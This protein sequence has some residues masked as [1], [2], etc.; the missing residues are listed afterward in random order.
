MFDTEGHVVSKYT[1]RM[2]S[3]YPQ[4]GWVEQDPYYIL[5]A[6]KTSISKALK[7][8]G[9]QPS[10]I[11]C[12]GITNQRETTIIWDR[13]T[14]IPVYNA[15]LW[16]DRRTETI[17]K[18]LSDYSMEISKK[19][20]LRLDP[21]FSAGKIKWILDNV[22][23]ARKRAMDGDLVF[24][25][26]DSWILFNLDRSRPCYTDYTNASRTML[27]DIRKL[28]WDSG[29]LSMFGIPDILLPDVFPSL[30]EFGSISIGRNKEIPVYSIIG[31]Q[32]SALFG[33]SSTSS[34]MAKITYGTGSFAMLNTGTD[35]PQSGALINTVA[36]GI[37][38]RKV[39]YALEGSVFSAGFALDWV[40]NLLHVRSFARFEEMAEK[41]R[42]QNSFMVP[43]FS[44]M[45]SPYWDPDA[46]GL[47]IG[48][49]GSSGR[50]DFARMAYESVAFQTEDVLREMEKA[51][52]IKAARVDGG[53][54]MSNFLMQLQAD[55]SGI[56]I[57][58]TGSPEIT[59]AGAAYIAGIA[60]GI[61][62]IDDIQG[63]ARIDKEY[64]PE[65]GKKDALERY[66][67]WKEAVTRS[68][69][70]ARF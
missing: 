61:W 16:Q 27:F 40:K 44:G 2:Q 39:N 24:G 47:I 17:M 69:K 22:K 57:M 63:M 5:S 54:S 7:G 28:E 9:I 66:P 64:T 70:W 8:A 62:E 11:Q 45:G 20:G 38:A 3:K 49:N 12:A 68:L 31:D 59:A 55:L 29:L 6:V 23:G 58:K 37:G 41:A 65:D 4:E 18:A 50:R 13:N 36:F 52:P 34:G 51:S 48:L 60:A 53:L 32:Q 19:T 21:Y 14:G 33:H 10:E 1:V 46:R 43:A 26:V 30:N 42:P 15:I 25:T 67:L 35:I 56:K